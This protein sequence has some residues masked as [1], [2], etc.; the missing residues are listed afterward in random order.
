MSETL[1]PIQSSTLVRGIYVETKGSAAVKDGFV[2]ISPAIVLYTA[3][4]KGLR[5][6]LRL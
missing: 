4:F 2:V 5:H 1:F 3:A 6:H